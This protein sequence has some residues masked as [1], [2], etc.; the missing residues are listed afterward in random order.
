MVQLNQEQAELCTQNLLNLKDNFSAY[1]Y[2]YQ[3]PKI[4]DFVIGILLDFFI[5]LDLIHACKCD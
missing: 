4:E 2:R 1:L 3:M 5:D